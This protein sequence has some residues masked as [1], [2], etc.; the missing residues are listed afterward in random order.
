MSESQ[1]TL[2]HMYY[3]FATFFWVTYEKNVTKCSPLFLTRKLHVYLLYYYI[4][5]VMQHL[6]K[7]Q[8]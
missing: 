2:L 8:K 3:S 1:P 7:I 6:L 5:W 4:F